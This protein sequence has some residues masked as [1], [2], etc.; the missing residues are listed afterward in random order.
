MIED[1][2]IIMYC[3]V[4]LQKLTKKIFS[5]FRQLLRKQNY[6]TLKH[7]EYRDYGAH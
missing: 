2:G 6:G 4:L 5:Y 3:N 7:Q 1:N